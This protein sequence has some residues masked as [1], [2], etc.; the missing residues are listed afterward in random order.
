M[1]N[2]IIAF[3]LTTVFLINCENIVYTGGAGGSEIEPECQPQ[4]TCE[5][6]QAECGSIDDG[7][8]SLIE[9]GECN[10]YK[11]QGACGTEKFDDNGESTIFS[12]NL[13]GGGCLALTK[14]DADFDCD[15]LY[16][17][18]NLSYY[19]WCTPYNGIANSISP[20]NLYC[21]SGVDTIIEHNDQKGLGYCCNE[22][23]D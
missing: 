6:Q 20:K 4:F 16:P 14:S 8:G 1:K 17:G 23:K 18:L 11:G 13:C 5:T 15:K 7:C 9:C 3:T 10:P 19:W 21:G 22:G 12:E 2:H